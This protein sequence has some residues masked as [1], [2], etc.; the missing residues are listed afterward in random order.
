MATLNHIGIAINDLPRMKKLFSILGLEVDHVESVPEQGVK[1]HFLPLPLDQ[2]SLE[3][4]EVQ[5]PEGVIAK[6]IQKKGPGIH[7]LSFSLSR[8]ELMPLCVKLKQSGFE[9][10]YEQSKLGAHGM[11]V[12]FI[13]PRTSGGILIEVMEP[14]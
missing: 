10:I 4:L 2:G 11:R 9:L 14:A 1:T 6:F 8:G 13:H 5:D 3:L 12:N 7:H